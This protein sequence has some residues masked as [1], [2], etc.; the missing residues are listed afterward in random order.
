MRKRNSSPEKLVERQII[1]HL[2]NLGFFMFNA[3]AKAIRT[4]SN[5][6]NVFYR[7]SGVMPGVSDLLGINPSG[8]FV[9]IELK[10]PGRRS[11]VSIKQIIFLERIILKGGFAAVI[12]SVEIFDLTYNTWAKLLPIDRPEYLL[13]LLPEII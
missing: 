3:E 2:T 11:T 5:T 7:N 13:S 9:A 6:G 12:D 10:A 1:D 8:K 4:I